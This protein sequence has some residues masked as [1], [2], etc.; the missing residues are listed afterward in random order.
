MRTLALIAALA[1]FGFTAQAQQNATIT[2]APAKAAQDPHMDA[3][4]TLSGQLKDSL[5]KVQQLSMANNKQLQA[6][7]GAEQERLG[8]LRTEIAG[9][10]NRLEKNLTTVNRST[11]ETFEAASTEAQA[12]MAMAEELIAKAKAGK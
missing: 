4:R 1:C 2:T 7:S 3:V 6:A 5:G 11:P 12:S 9:M 10:M 8:L